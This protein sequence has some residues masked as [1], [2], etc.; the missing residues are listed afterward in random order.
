[1]PEEK[2]KVAYTLFIIFILIF[3]AI[4]STGLLTPQPGDE[5][6]YY[7]MGKL[8]TE[9]KVPYKDF[10]FAHPPLQIYLIAFIYRIFGFN[11]IALKLI[12][13]ISTLISAFFIFR[14]TKE[15]FG[16]YAAII[17]S[18]L[19]LFAYGVMFN[20]VFSFG[21]DIAAMFLVI[22]IYL[23]FNKNYYIV[24]GIFFGLAGITRLLL[25]IPL[26]VIFAAVLIS[27]KKI[28]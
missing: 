4:A 16:N 7:Y 3:V 21:V 9:G 8:I 5:N 25:I 27:S 1:M 18:L 28:F 2:T 6:T 22:G 13:L 11:I 23:L 19:F 14:I 12:P 10:F 20:S 15:K 24:S 17:S 26:T